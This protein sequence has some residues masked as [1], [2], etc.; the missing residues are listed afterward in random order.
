MCKNIHQHSSLGFKG[1]TGGNA[2]LFAKTRGKIQSGSKKKFKL[3]VDEILWGKCL[4]KI[5]L[6][7]FEHVALKLGECF[8]GSEGWTFL[9]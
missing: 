2:K 8:I 6:R 3:A 7:R 4:R 1:K 5:C 9:D